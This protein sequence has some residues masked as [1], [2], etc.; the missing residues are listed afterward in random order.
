MKICLLEHPRKPAED[1][2][3]DIANTTLAS[4]LNSGYLAANLLKAGH[5][6][7]LIEGYMEHLSYDAI[8]K[9]VA[10]FG[11]ELLAVHLVYNWEDNH[12]L[13]DFLTQL[14]AK[15]HIRHLNVYG[16]YPTFAYEEVL[17]RCPAIDS[18]MLGE[19]ELTV[20]ELANHLDAWQGVKGLAYRDGDGFK[21]SFG[22]LVKDLDSLPFP[23]RKATSYPGGEVNI[24]GS[25]GCYNTCTFCYI[26][27]YYGPDTGCPR[28]RGRS[29]ENILAEIDQVIAQTD[30]R[31]FYFDDPNFFGPGENGRKRVLALAKL[32]K[33]RP[34]TFG[35]EARAND[36]D[37]ET[38]Q[39]LVDAGM[40][41]ILVGLESGRQ[42]VL[43][44]LGK[45]T[46]VAQNEEAL[47][48]L[49]RHGIEPNVGFIMFEPDS[50]FDDL[51]ENF[52]F[53]KRNHLLDR[54]EISVNVLYHHQIILAG[55]ASYFALQQEGRLHISDHSVYEATTDY[56]H[57]DVSAF[58]AFMRRIT[59]HIFDWSASTWAAAAAGEPEARAAFDRV[60]AVL[61]GWFK[62]ILDDPSKLTAFDA[63]VAKADRDIDQA[64]AN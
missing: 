42:D 28:W 52:A 8:E 55:S 29:P 27:P 47:K 10:A 44:R 60:N 21:A 35:I 25:R 41:D 30:H 5:C 58:A 13:F 50:T 1:R 4:C 32:L 14:K 3:N 64:I 18:A 37:E 16:Y 26:N 17:T 45:H 36:I 31:Y 34:I 54:L 15:Y 22:P 39:A 61:V 62:A 20:V 43:D 56:I 6:V 49:R 12:V 11:P 33:T 23:I 38:T 53:L 51:R 7:D 59:N 9:E 19:N 57:P 40:T 24:L 63:L 2:Q 48:I 46:T